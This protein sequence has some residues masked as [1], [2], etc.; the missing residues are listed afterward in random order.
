MCGMLIPVESNA[1]RRVL[2]FL[3]AMA[4]EQLLG[5]RLF[6]GSPTHVGAADEEAQFVNRNVCD[7]DVTRCES[8]YGMATSKRASFS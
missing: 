3:R 2:L 5:G 8:L 1:G 6:S 4:F 7:D